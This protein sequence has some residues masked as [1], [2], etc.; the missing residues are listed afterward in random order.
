[1][2]VKILSG[3]SMG[4][5]SKL[6]NVVPVYYLDFK[7]EPGASHTQEVFLFINFVKCMNIS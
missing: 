6:Q 2:N 7:L 1:M 4:A 3:Q 5:A